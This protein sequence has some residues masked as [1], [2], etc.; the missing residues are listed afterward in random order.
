MRHQ[1]VVAH[2]IQVPK[3]SLPACLC[4]QGSNWNLRESGPSWTPVCGKSP[5]SQGTNPRLGRTRRPATKPRGQRARPS[6]LPFAS[7]L[8]DQRSGTTTAGRAPCQ[9][10]QLRRR[11]LSSTQRSY[12]GGCRPNHDC[13]ESVYQTQLLNPMFGTIRSAYSPKGKLVRCLLIKTGKYPA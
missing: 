9:R 3:T 7:Q 10:S 11:I 2:P 4:R 6:I 5:P 8:Q 13:I 1:P 12:K